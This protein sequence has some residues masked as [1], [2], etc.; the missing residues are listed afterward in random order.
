MPI[1]VCPFM[2]FEP[3]GLSHNHSPKTIGCEESDRLVA[4]AVKSLRNVDTKQCKTH[5]D[6]SRKAVGEY[7]H[8]I[9]RDEDWRLGSSSPLYLHKF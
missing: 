8:Q 5:N 7:D 2:L 1:D 3:Q 4:T 9:L 6:E